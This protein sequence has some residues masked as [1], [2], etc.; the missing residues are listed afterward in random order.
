[1]P[2]SL[3]LG[4]SRAR[5]ERKNHS[6]GSGSSYKERK[7]CFNRRSNK[8]RLTCGT[9]RE[10]LEKT[11]SFP[12]VTSLVSLES[13]NCGLVTMERKGKNLSPSATEKKKRRKCERVADKRLVPERRFDRRLVSTSC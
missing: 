7:G 8:K 12:S 10:R 3:Q 1:M 4:H 9:M 5:R 2:S 13:C 11:S 6:A